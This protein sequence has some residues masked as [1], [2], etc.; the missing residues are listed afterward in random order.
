MYWATLVGGRYRAAIPA[1]IV[2]IAIVIAAG[3]P[4]FS[5]FEAHRAGYI[6]GVLKAGSLSCGTKISTSAQ[7]RLQYYMQADVVAFTA[8]STA[9]ATLVEKT[10]QA[11]GFTNLCR[12]LVERYA[13]GA[14][15]PLLMAFPSELTETQWPLL[16]VAVSAVLLL[17]LVL[18]PAIRQRISLF[19]TRRR[20]LF[21][22]WL[23]LS[24]MWI[25]VVAVGTSWNWPH[26]PTDRYVLESSSLR[27]RI[28]PVTPE[29]RAAHI[30]NVVLF[31]MTASGLAI[32][33]PIV[34]LLILRRSRRTAPAYDNAS[35]SR[36][37]PSQDWERTYGSGWKLLAL[38]GL[39]A[40][41]EVAINVAVP[42][43]VW[44]SD[45]HPLFAITGFLGSAFAPFIIGGVIPFILWAI[46][47][48]K[49]SAGN[50]MMVVWAG[51]ILLFAWF[52]FYGLPQQ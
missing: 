52:Q 4:F 24:A 13:R 17:L 16:L 25:V 28:I 33:P 38:F 34:L 8:G 10:R 27:T 47:G 3:W 7:E 11:A 39:S 21:G 22:G 12:L 6:S 31:L 48:F 19:V 23:L 18:R 41:A 30:R 29:D 46:T 50:Q 1:I 49:R 26:E 35:A 20:I 37:A 15:R 42:G 5:N 51:L 45:I 43:S 2:V 32:G 9:G 14:E 36:R 40:A 44:Q